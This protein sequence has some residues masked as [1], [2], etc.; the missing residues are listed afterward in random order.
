MQRGGKD[1]SP[2]QESVFC[3]CVN[4]VIKTKDFLLDSDTLGGC[5]S[6][7]LFK[8]GSAAECHLALLHSKEIRQCCTKYLQNLDSHT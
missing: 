3:Y 8:T 6:V 7:Q 2:L 5:S 4:K 1:S